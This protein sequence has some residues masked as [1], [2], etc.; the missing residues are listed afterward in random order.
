MKP[1]LRSYVPETDFSRVRDF[2]VETYAVFGR[3]L[4]WRIERWNYARYFVAPMLGAYGKKEPNIEHSHQAICFWEETIGVWEDRNKEIAGVVNME[5]PD[6][7]HPGFGEAFLQRHPDHTDL[8]DEMLEYAET[9]LRNKKTDTLHIYVYEKDDQLEN[10]LTIRG[11]RKDRERV[12][13]DSELIIKDLPEPRLPSGYGLRSMADE[14][15]IELRR[16][17]FGRS[18]NHLDPLEWPSAY[19][20]EE[21]QRAPDYRRD[22]DLYIVHP[23]GAYVACCIAWYDGHNQIGILEPVGT[24]PDFRGVGLGKE[25]TLEGI[26]RVAALGAEKVVVGSGQRFYE[27]I[28]FRKK[29]ASYRWMKQF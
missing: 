22:L 4:N 21:L 24:H 9:T 14:N 23:D 27:S 5:H 25:V 29:Y 19:S 3:T 26:R 6:P 17:I 13:Y 10:A 15:N 7:E 16:E 2:L 28:G 20:Y 11:Y 12:A 8:F 1:T 18:F